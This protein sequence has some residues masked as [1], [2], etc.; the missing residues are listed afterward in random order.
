MVAGLI[1]SIWS[2]V[3]T[4]CSEAIDVNTISSIKGTVYRPLDCPEP[5]RPLPKQPKKVFQHHA[6]PAPG[7]ESKTASSAAVKNRMPEADNPFIDRDL[8][9]IHEV[10]GVFE[11][12]RLRT[13]IS[14]YVLHRLLP[15][16]IQSRVSA[17]NLQDCLTR[18]KPDLPFPRPIAEAIWT[19][20]SKI[21]SRD[22]LILAEEALEPPAFGYF[23]LPAVK[24]E[25]ATQQVR[26]AIHDKGGRV[27]DVIDRMEGLNIS[28]SSVTRII[29][30][31]KTRG[32]VPRLYA[33]YILAD[34]LLDTKLSPIP[35][36][37][38]RREILQDQKQPKLKPQPL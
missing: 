19:A 9:F 10:R 16:E 33:A 1:N 21:P 3:Q 18:R 30:G 36:I 22:E 4:D 28:R 29:H 34:L 32:T 12:E 6:D 11:R 38:D 37:G 8:V 5:L 24:T 27:V 15:K 35:T 26:Q 13:H 23:F 20:F 7:A 25:M 14:S 17:A 2:L 31:D